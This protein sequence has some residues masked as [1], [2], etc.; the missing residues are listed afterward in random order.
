MYVETAKP[1][2]F[3]PDALSKRL[4]HFITENQEILP[5]A[6]DALGQSDLDEFGRLVDASQR[7]AERL[8]GNQI[9]QTSYLAASARE[10]GA[11]AASAFGAGFGGG[12]WAMV[13]REQV[14]DFLASWERAYR[15]RFSLQADVASFFATEAGPAAFRV[16]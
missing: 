11:V 16:C 7:A 1:A 4:E 6:G 2:E 9:P 12:V 13:E 15:G 10:H 8:L 3:A 5:A 14:A